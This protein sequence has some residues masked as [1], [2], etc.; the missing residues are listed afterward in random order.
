MNSDWTQ[1][2]RSHVPRYNADSTPQ[3][4]CTYNHNGGIFAPQN[5]R[6]LPQLYFGHSPPLCWGW[7]LGASFPYYLWA[8]MRK[9]STYSRALKEHFAHSHPQNVPFF[10]TSKLKY[11]GTALF[12]DHSHFLGHQPLN[13][14]EN[15][16]WTF[17]DHFCYF[18][19]DRVGVT[20]RPIS[21]LLLDLFLNNCFQNHLHQNPPLDF[22]SLQVQNSYVLTECL[23]IVMT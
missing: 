1:V 2:R 11:C 15:L 22:L 18:D 23:K 5:G 20:Y 9:H 17:F 13:A 4:L 7:I 14:P 21:Q 19:W 12:V 10:P 8:L 6:Y 16:D 3:S